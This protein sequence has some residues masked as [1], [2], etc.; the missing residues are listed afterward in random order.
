[1]MT[2]LHMTY[3]KNRLQLHQKRPLLLGEHESL[4]AGSARVVVVLRHLDELLKSW[5]QLHRTVQHHRHAV[6]TGRNRADNLQRLE[7][8]ADT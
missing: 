6:P 1:M 7:I 4:Q 5:A 8:V 3:M 2:L